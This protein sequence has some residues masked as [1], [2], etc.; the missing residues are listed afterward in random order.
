MRSPLVLALCAAVLAAPAPVALA[1]AHHPAKGH[2][3]AK[4]SKGSKGDPGPAGPK[5]DKGDPGP[6]GPAGQ[7]GTNGTNGTS[8][9]GAATLPVVLSAQCSSACGSRAPSTSAPVPLNSSTWT[10]NVGEID[11]ILIDGQ[12]DSSLSSCTGGG[13]GLQLQ[14]QVSGVALG[15]TYGATPF[16]QNSLAAGVFTNVAFGVLGG[17]VGPPFSVSAQTRNVTVFANNA[18]TAGTQYAIDFL[19]VVVVRLV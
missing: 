1:K 12:F 16:P 17:F 10:Q 18:C 2:K 8:G 4:G 6:A 11:E 9:G 14:V 19:R 5:G 7:N 15:A 3:G 13:G